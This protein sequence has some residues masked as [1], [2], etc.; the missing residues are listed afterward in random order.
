[1]IAVRRQQCLVLSRHRC[2]RDPM[3]LPNACATVLFQA[4]FSHVFVG[5]KKVYN[6]E[7]LQ[8]RSA[9]LSVSEQVMFEQIIFAY[10]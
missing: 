9:R 10:F 4:Q 6:V 2:T 5:E 8:R 1:M 7:S 3:R